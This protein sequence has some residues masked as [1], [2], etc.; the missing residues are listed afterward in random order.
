MAGSG[1]SSSRCGKMP[2]LKP[3]GWPGCPFLHT[4]SLPH[5]LGLVDRLATLLIWGRE[6]MFVP[7]SA[8]EAYKNAIAGSK[9]VVL[10]KCGHRPEV[11]KSAEFVNELRSFLS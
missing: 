1:P 2:G 3:R 10:D 9:L 8:A 6:D 4:P 5:L 11:E 7:L